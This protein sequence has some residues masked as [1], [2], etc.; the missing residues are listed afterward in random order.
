MSSLSY[1]ANYVDQQEQAENA[2]EA[3]AAAA[4]AAAEQ[5]QRQYA[6]Q[7]HYNEWY[8]TTGRYLSFPPGGTTQ[9]AL[10]QAYKQEFNLEGGRRMRY[11]STRRR[12]KTN[13]RRGKTHRRRHRKH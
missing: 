6:L 11:K 7:M 1:W 2:R 4:A 3:A 8:Q 9:A 13:R 5:Q 12:G 10:L